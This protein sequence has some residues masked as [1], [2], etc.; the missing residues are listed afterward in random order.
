RSSAVVASQPSTHRYRHSGW[1]C[2]SIAEPRPV[3]TWPTTSL[4]SAR[5]ETGADTVQQ[6]RMRGRKGCSAPAFRAPGVA[7]LPSAP[8]CG[9][10]RSHM[11]TSLLCLPFVGLTFWAAS[12]QQPQPRQ[13][14]FAAPVR[15]QAGGEVIKVESPGYAFPCWADVDGDG[16]PDLV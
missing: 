9:A 10:R 15:M 8:T 13:V 5:G 16:V 3:A 11:L 7:M 1:R 6:D 12:P 4:A 14:Q 2:R